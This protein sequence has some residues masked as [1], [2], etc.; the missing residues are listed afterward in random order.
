MAAPIVDPIKNVT[1]K[2]RQLTELR[3]DIDRN[4]QQIAEAPRA[5]Q[6]LNSQSDNRTTT[7]LVEELA[8]IRSDWEDRLETAQDK[9]LSNETRLQILQDNEVPISQR[10]HNGLKDFVLGR[11]PTLLLAISAAA[12]VWLLFRALWWLPGYSLN[13]L[14]ARQFGFA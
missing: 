9:M 8:A 4:Q 10:L 13:T 7:A 3:A 1:E 2:S 11:G 14:G 5:I 12:F 6:I